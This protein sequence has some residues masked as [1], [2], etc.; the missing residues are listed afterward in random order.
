MKLLKI[1]AYSS[2]AILSQ[3]CLAGAA[4]A[5]FVSRPVN[6]GSG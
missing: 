1:R 4:A 6:S 3:V 2:E 5:L